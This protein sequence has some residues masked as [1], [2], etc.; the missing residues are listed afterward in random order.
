MECLILLLLFRKI[1]SPV[2]IIGPWLRLLVGLKT[3]RKEPNEYA[4][5]DG[6]FNF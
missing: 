1:L 5:G 2:G 6:H 3:I 4:S